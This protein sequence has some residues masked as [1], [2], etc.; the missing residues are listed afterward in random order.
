M[1][2][3]H[4]RKVDRYG[5]GRIPACSFGTGR[6]QNPFPDLKDDAILLCN[7][8]ELGRRDGSQFRMLPAQKGLIA[9]NG[10]VE[11]V[12]CTW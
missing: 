1:D 8:Y 3:L 7:R 9:S 11:M 2:Q 4:R 5:I 6:P 10:P 12:V